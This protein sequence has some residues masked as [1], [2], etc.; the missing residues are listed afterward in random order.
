ML[1]S[2]AIPESVYIHVEEVSDVTYVS[3]RAR[4]KVKAIGTLTHWDVQNLR[5]TK[6][7]MN[8]VAPDSGDEP[9]TDLSMV[10]MTVYNGVA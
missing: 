8:R 6:P 2:G 4:V 9:T 5:K 7:V 1:T 3:D 10:S